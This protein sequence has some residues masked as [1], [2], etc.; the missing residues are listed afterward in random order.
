MAHKKMRN[1]KFRIFLYIIYKN[2]FLE[3]HTQH[4]TVITVQQSFN[5][6]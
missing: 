1:L 3:F 4:H 5:S 6:A 2:L